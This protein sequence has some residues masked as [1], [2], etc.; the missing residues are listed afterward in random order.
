MPSSSK[1][2]A[3]FFFALFFTSAVLTR[4]YYPLGIGNKLSYCDCLLCVADFQPL[5]ILVRCGWGVG[6]C[7][8]S[9]GESL[10]VVPALARMEIWVGASKVSCSAFFF[11]LLFIISP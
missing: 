8:D 6:F 9:H 11:L 7:W 3:G 5:K 1:K 2:V 4:T 10:A